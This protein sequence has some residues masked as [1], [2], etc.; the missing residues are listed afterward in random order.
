MTAPTEARRPSPADMAPHRTP[1]PVKPGPVKATAP[2]PSAPVSLTTAE[3]IAP[4]Q[5]G[6]GENVRSLLPR[7]VRRSRMHPN[8][9]LVVLT[10]LN[11]AN[12]K[13]GLVN[14]RHRPDVE[15]LAEDTGLTTGQ[16]EVQLHVLTQRGWLYER[17]LTRGAQAG[18]TGL[19]V[20]VPTVYLDQVRAETA[21]YA[22]ERAECIARATGDDQ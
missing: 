6:R 18:Q 17:T 21:A 13:T 10:L 12:F 20:T 4:G 14:S 3:A 2:G 9:R 7:A 19:F 11:Y 15:Q 22:A 16:I 8:S 5:I 1:A